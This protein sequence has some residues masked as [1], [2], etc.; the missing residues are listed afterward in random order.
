MVNLFDGP[1]GG[2]VA[3]IMARG[4]VEAEAIAILAPAP[5]A[6]FW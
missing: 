5:D 1:L 2:L 6:Q 4:N 3:R